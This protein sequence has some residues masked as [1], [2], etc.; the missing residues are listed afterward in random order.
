MSASPQPAAP[1][2]PTPDPGPDDAPPQGAEKPILPYGPV[3]ANGPTWAP[4]S[5]T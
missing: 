4:F 2:A 5:K 1:E 3:I